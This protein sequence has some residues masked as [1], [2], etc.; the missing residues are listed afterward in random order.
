[1]VGFG[2]VGLGTARFVSVRFGTGFLVRFV[3]A[4]WGEV[5]LGFRA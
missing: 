3:K 5:G 1:V 2:S 4:R